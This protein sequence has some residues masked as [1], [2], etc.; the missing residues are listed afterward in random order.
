MQVQIQKMSTTD[1]FLS[2]F[3]GIAGFPPLFF[4]VFMQKSLFFSLF[5][6]SHKGFSAKIDKI[7]ICGR[8]AA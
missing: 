4:H 5:Q 6:F 1:K 2:F 8:K 7:C 3:S